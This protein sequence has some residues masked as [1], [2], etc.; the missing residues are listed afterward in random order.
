MLLLLLVPAHKPGWLAAAWPL[1]M[2][3]ISRAHYAL[4]LLL[5]HKRQGH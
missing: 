3:H 5:Q 2:R 4:L 1:E